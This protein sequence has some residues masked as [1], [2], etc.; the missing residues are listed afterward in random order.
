MKSLQKINRVRAVA[1]V[2]TIAVISALIGTSLT[3]RTEAAQIGTQPE[4]TVG[5]HSVFYAYLKTGEKLEASWIFQSLTGTNGSRGNPDNIDFTGLVIGPNDTVATPSASC[6]LPAGQPN[7]AVCS[8][9]YTATTDGIYKIYSPQSTIRTVRNMTVRTAADQVITGRIWANQ[10]AFYQTAHQPEAVTTSMMNMTYYAVNDAGNIYKIDFSQY[11][12]L[13]STIAL[14]AAGNVTA[15]NSCT[16]SYISTSQSKTGAAIQN[17][18]APFRTPNANCTKYRMFV[19]GAPNADL[20][21]SAPSVDGDLL[22]L[23]VKAHADTTP[24][25]DLEPQL[26]PANLISNLKFTETATAANK[27]GKLTFNIDPTFAGNYKVLVDVNND[28]GYDDA[29]DRAYNASAAGGTSSVSVN[30]DGKDG[31]G[32]DITPSSTI[33]FA[34][35]FDR[36]GEIHIVMSDTEGQGGMSATLMNGASA[37]S[38]KLY[39]DDTQLTTMAQL[40]GI[41]MN[42]TLILDGTAGVVSDVVGGVHGWDFDYPSYPDATNCMEAS[43]GVALQCGGWGNRRSIDTWT[44]IAS[45]HQANLN[46]VAGPRYIVKFVSNG[47]TAVTQQKVAPSGVAVNKTTTRDGYTFE[48]W[49]IDPGFSGVPYDFA[50]LVNSDITLYARW[51]AITYHVHYSP[52][53]PDASQTMPDTDAIYDETVATEGNTFIRDGWTF[54]GWNTEPDGSGTFYANLYEFE[55]YAT[56]GDTMLYAQWVKVVYPEVSLPSVPNTGVTKSPY[57]LTLKLHES[58][59]KLISPKSY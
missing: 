57:Q 49:F 4:A 2:F 20:P 35:K 52:N 40:P 29:V 41:I 25:A 13:N 31:Q 16:S 50:T 28:G 7:G 18:D 8:V 11:N 32:N 47:G 53:Y 9:D 34:I 1:I 55:P 10:I 46:A 33:R 5:A 59:T 6:F 15:D 30:F 26:D 12:G 36:M 27:A 23:P 19:D 14:N 45:D 43:T 3:N 44:F 37:G 51:T 48:D 22:V 17:G 42:E 56:A 58:L 38:N 39:W 54:I 24:L 21:V